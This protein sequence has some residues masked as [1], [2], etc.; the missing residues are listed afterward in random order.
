M[1]IFNELTYGFIGKK[2]HVFKAIDLGDIVEIGMLYNKIPLC[3][4]QSIVEV[5]DGNLDPPIILIVVP[6]MPVHTNM[7]HVV[8][9]L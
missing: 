7:T 3:V 2:W 4:I 1:S 9:A 5:D 8:C 6:N